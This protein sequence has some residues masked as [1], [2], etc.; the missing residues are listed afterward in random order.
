VYA[1]LAGFVALLDLC[2]ELVAVPGESS[3]SFRRSFMPGLEV[4]CLLISGN[5]PRLDAGACS[6]SCRV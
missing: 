1:D 5:L 2:A 4:V 6:V 3:A